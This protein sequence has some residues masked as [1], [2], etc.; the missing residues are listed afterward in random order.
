METTTVVISTMRTLSFVGISL[1]VSYIDLLAFVSTKSVLLSI[2][3]LQTISSLSV[4][5]ITVEV[6]KVRSVSLPVS[7]CVFRLGP[8]GVFFLKYIGPVKFLL[9]VPVSY[10]GKAIVAFHKG[11]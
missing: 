1:T 11:D 5:Y 4:F 3:V 7:L 9:L 8:P 6:Y 2:T 10:Y